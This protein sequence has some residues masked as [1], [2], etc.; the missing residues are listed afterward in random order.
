MIRQN[1]LIL[2]EFEKNGALCTSDLAA[3]LGMSRQ[4]VH[5]HLSAMIRSGDIIRLGSGKR[6][7]SYL[8][9]TA[10]ARGKFLGKKRV[11]NKRVRVAGLAEDRLLSEVEAQP[12]LFS[13]LSAAALAIIRYAFTEM[14]NNAVDHSGAKRIEIRVS[15]DRA[16]VSF[17]VADAG[18]GVFEN[19]RAKKG[20]AD[21]MEAIQDLL[22]GKT[23]TAPEAHSGEGIFF[24]SKAVDRFVLE[25]HRKRLT[26][27][28]VGE[29]VFV[30]NCRFRKGTRVDICVSTQSRRDLSEIFHGYTG[31]KFQF[32]KSRIAVKLFASENAYLSRS[33]AKR[34]LHSMA[35]FKRIELDF[36]GVPTVGQAF[37]DEVFRVFKKAHP[38]IEITA[39]NCNENVE[40]MIQRSLHCEV[41]KS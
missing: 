34:L 41:A 37:A 38:E 18:V 29:D 15:V 27:D 33:Q 17:R 16:Q 14:V 21:E 39:I 6:N 5:K 25:S 13:G 30:E 40:F 10:A 3:R 2:K 32:D 35:S 23:T 9:N 24:T 8:L 1:R 7:A 11:F 20:L 4:A 31:E 22:K 36:A 26:V 28:N 12:V 19:I